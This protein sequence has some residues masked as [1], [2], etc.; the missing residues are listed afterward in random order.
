MTE[1]SRSG[2]DGNGRTRLCRAGL[3]LA[4]ALGLTACGFTPL[5]GEKASGGFARTALQDVAVAPAGLDRTE[6]LLRNALIRRLTPQ[7]QPAS[8]TY[9]LEYTTSDTL[10]DLLVQQ[11]AEVLRRNY[12]LTARYT[13]R[14][15][16]D[17]EVLF[18]GSETRS[19]SLNRLDSEYANV[20]AERDARA[21]AAAS[22]AD[23]IAQ[24]LA[25][26]LAT[27]ESPEGKRAA[28]LRAAAAPKPADGSTRE[29]GFKGFPRPRPVSPDEL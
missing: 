28:A 21:R 1:N 6:Q 14:H 16:A 11:N 4:A 20:I 10:G 22:L 15:V 3:A 8:P 29:P 19:A 23:A 9:R 26:V 24:R 25:V 5:Y 7:G 18:Q 12:Q 13:L 2:S 17:G 27:A